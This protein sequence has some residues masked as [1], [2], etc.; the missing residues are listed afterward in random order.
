MGDGEFHLIFGRSSLGFQKNSLELQQ[1]LKKILKNDVKGLIVAI[2]HNIIYMDDLLP[3]SFDFWRH[4]YGTLYYKLYP[5]LVKNKFYADTGL[6]RLY[7]GYKDKNNPKIAERFAKVRLLW[8]GQNIIIVEGTDSKLG[9]INNFFANSASLKRIIC[10]SKN[11]FEKIET[12]EKEIVN[13]YNKDDII[14]L[15]L[16]PTATVLAYNLAQKGI[17]SL[18]LGHIDVEYEWFKMKATD[19][20]P[21]KGK[22][23]N[24]VVNTQSNSESFKNIE[25]ENSIIITL[26]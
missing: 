15:A 19:K 20:V 16:G 23:L 2:P 11:A 1:S 24:E 14:I 25:Y 21:I 7:M 8:E 6:S 22:I 9:T 17:R 18:D 26:T 4:F 12:I 5:I 3:Y 13:N 10:P